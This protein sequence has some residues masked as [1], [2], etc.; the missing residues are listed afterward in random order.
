MSALFQDWVNGS[1]TVDLVAPE[2]R[3]LYSNDMTLIGVLRKD[4][5]RGV[6]LPQVLSILRFGDICLSQ[7]TIPPLSAVRLS[8]SHL[9]N[10]AFN[11]LINQLDPEADDTR[12]RCPH[13]LDTDFVFSRERNH[14]VG[15]P[16]RRMPSSIAEEMRDVCEQI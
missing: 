13:V 6:A 12:K 7:F 4:C 3:V 5:E 9:T 2:T 16:A 1:C 14:K 8:Q 10:L 15:G 11:A